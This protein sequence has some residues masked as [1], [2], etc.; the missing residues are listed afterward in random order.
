MKQFV[1][2]LVVCS[3]AVAGWG[4]KK[5]NDAGASNGGAKQ[6]VV[7][8]MPKSKGNDYFKACKV[9]A[10]K[11]AKELNVKLIWDGPTTPDPPKQNDMVDSWITRGV[12]VIAVSCDNGAAISSALK[13]AQDAGIKVV[14]YD[15]DS[16][17][18][19][20]DFFVNQGTPEAIGN[21]LMDNAAAAMG[22]KG[23]FAI[24]TASLTASNMIAWQKT[25]EARLK[26]KYPDITLVDTQACNDNDKEAYSRATTILGSHPN[27]RLI[28]AICSPAVPAAADAVTKAGKAKQVKVM[29]LGLPSMN[30]TWVKDGVTDCIILWNPIDLGYLAVQTA[31]AA[32]KGTLKKGDASFDVPNWRKVEIKGDNV[33][34]GAPVKFTKENIDQY[35]F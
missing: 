8:V 5:S 16:S 12:D 21:A 25:I 13:R 3:M 22:N 6:L 24:I 23:E 27:V 14:T 32:K 1:A 11:A 30:K 20:R 18:D 7:A 17:P 4:C 29:G 28:M 2:S 31:V 34:L 10:D 9:G 33:I 15:A 35:D 19:S 26:E